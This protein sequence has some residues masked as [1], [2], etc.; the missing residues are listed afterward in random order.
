MLDLSLNRGKIGVKLLKNNRGLSLIEILSAVVL[1]SIVSVF[2]VTQ[3]NRSKTKSLTKQAKLQ[4]GHLHRMEK[5]Y[6]Q[7]HKTYT[8]ELRG[9]MFP[10]GVQLYNVGFGY[11]ARDW[12]R[13]HCAYFHN[14]EQF[15]NNYYELCGKDFK[16]KDS[17]SSCGFTNKHGNFP[18]LHAYTTI[19]GNYAGQNP[20]NSFMPHDHCGINRPKGINTKEQRRIYCRDEHKD[21]L[22]YG[23]VKR[24]YPYNEERY[25][26]RFIAYAWGDILDPKEFSSPVEK[27]DG[28]RI[29]GSGYLEHCQNPFEDV[30]SYSCGEQMTI[31]ETSS[32][33]YCKNTRYI[34]EGEARLRNRQNNN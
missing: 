33:K 22:F 1:L 6:F 26:N 21:G 3:Y 32:D 14:Y 12:K 24:R 19:R 17:L 29:S 11:R 34:T 10:K 13:N 28:W 20:G 4:L 30:S 25:Y 5:M 8:F 15:K 31:S 7:E 16:T 9:N 27:L 23:K 2:S 18:T